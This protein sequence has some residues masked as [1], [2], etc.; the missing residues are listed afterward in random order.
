NRLGLPTLKAL[1]EAGRIGEVEKLADAAPT[2]S[3]ADVQLLP[4]IPDPAHIWCLA[5]NY[6][7]HIDEIGAIGIQ[8]EAPKYPALFMRYADTLV[9]H[10]APLVKPKVSD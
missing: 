8:R 9:A 3:L 7:D 5:I 10:G 1:L 6:Q 2:L 4:V